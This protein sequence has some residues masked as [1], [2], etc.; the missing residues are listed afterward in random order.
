MKRAL[1]VYSIEIDENIESDS[2]V[3]F[4]ALVD[5]PAIQ[6]NF[7]AFSDQNGHCSISIP[8]DF[9]HSAEDKHLVYGPL[10][11]ADLPIYRN[12]NGEECYVTFSRDTIEKMALK[13]QKKGYQKNVNLQHDSALQMEGITMF[14][15][16]ITNKELGIAPLKGY[17]DAGEGSWF[18]AF[19]V[20]NPA[21]WQL[22]KEGKVK[23]FSIEGT[24]G[25]RPVQLS[26][27]EIF[28]KIADILSEVS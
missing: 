7:L 26:E 12:F 24:F 4:V 16:W 2:E 19:K 27:E 8:I 13:F 22:I 21:V 28:H 20:E 9:A 15:S 5:R 14:Q 6:K 1:P 18:G 3:N 11:L 25:L 10:M 17:E 23:G